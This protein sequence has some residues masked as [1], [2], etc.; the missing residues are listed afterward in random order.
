MATPRVV[1]S[2]AVSK[3]FS[4]GCPL[5]GA[6]DRVDV[7]G[8][9]AYALAIHVH[10]GEPVR[11]GDGELMPL[12]VDESVGERE[13][14]AVVVLAAHRDLSIRDV[15]VEALFLIAGAA[16]AEQVLPTDMRIGLEPRLERAGRIS[17][18]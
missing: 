1:P 5:S 8:C 11:V 6:S 9:A 2:I 3:Y 7:Y 18:G 12:G 13:V 14:R 16:V 17:D 10:R 4:T 15:D